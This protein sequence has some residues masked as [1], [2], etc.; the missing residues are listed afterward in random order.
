MN[1]PN[2]DIIKA[3]I[4]STLTAEEKALGAFLGAMH[5][6]K[7]DGAKM[8][9]AMLRVLGITG[10]AQ[11]AEQAKGQEAVG[12]VYISHHKGMENRD[13]DYW[14]NLPDGSHML[15]PTPPAQPAREWV[16]LT[17]SDRRT[18]WDEVQRSKEPDDFTYAAAIE[19]KLREKNAGLPA[20]D[21]KAGG[22]FIFARARRRL[23]DVADARKEWPDQ[24]PVWLWQFSFDDREFPNADELE[25]VT[26]YARPQPQAEALR[27]PDG[28][29]LVP[30][31]PT[32]E[33]RD[34]GNEVILDRGKLFRAWKAMLSAAPQT[35]AQTQEA[36][37]PE[38][39]GPQ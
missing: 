32:D 4:A 29:V 19:S 31:E 10:E 34:A 18:V 20:A 38:Q 16:G 28:Y 8:R 2:D 7:L 15:Y 9:E 1:Q 6:C 11:P 36:L 22:E 14:G 25:Q 27:V 37:N 30:V 13:F 33:M 26:L 12:S 24:D 5:E 21:A 39:R 23:S 3:A 35:A 17:D